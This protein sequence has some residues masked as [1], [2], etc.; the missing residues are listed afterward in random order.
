[1]SIELELAHYGVKGMKWGTR[2]ARK[3]GRKAGKLHIQSVNPY[4]IRSVHSRLNKMALAQ[5]VMDK[6]KNDPDFIEGYRDAA[7]KRFRIYDPVKGK[8]V[9]NK[10]PVARAG[11]QE[12]LEKAVRYYEKDF[13]QRVRDIEQIN[14]GTYKPKP[15]D[16]GYRNNV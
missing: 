15:G 14:A 5:K 2:K 10:D 1:M 11:A 3:A 7:A 9:S 12:A 16:Y 8:V 4:T 6:H 13:K